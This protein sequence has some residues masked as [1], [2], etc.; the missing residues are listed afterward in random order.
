MSRITVAN[1]R[2]TLSLG[3]AGENLAREL[4]FDVSA[5]LSE[6]GGSGTVVLLHQR[7]GDDAPYPVAVT[8]EDGTVLWAVTSADVA[9]PG[10]GMA[11]LQYIVDEVVVKSA[12][13]STRVLASLDDP[14]DAPDPESGW[15][16]DMIARIEELVGD[17]VPETQ[18]VWYGM[19]ATASDVAAKTAMTAG[20]LSEV[21]RGVSI[22][23]MLTRGN[24]SANPTLN[25]DDL[26]AYPIR[27][28]GNVALGNVGTRT[29][30]DLVFTGDYWAVVGDVES[31]GGSSVTVDSAL[32]G[33]SANPV[34]N[35]AIYN[36]L[37]GKVDVS[38]GVAN[39]GKFLV[40]GNDGNVTAVTMAAWTGGSY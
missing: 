23:I 1:P 34:Q 2:T 21:T 27:T 38:Q 10:S 18:R 28:S 19:C 30:L 9:K 13:W 16:A 39:A 36:A 5:W 24:T 3:H 15:V 7:Y 33:S 31:S 17:G 14:G 26:G 40:V 6:Y 20:G 22:H 4:A 11:E 29:V 37:A 32:S 35:Q 12:I 25:V 8:V